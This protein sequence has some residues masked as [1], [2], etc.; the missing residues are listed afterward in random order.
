MRHCVTRAAIVAPPS[1]IH[2]ALAISSPGHG[3]TEPERSPE[4]K[5][6]QTKIPRAITSDATKTS[7]HVIAGD[8]RCRRDAKSASMPRP[9]IHQKTIPKRRVELLGKAHEFDTERLERLKS[10]E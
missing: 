6:S 7:I 4:R 2:I 10:P 5:D 3:K 1:R 9:A 8:R